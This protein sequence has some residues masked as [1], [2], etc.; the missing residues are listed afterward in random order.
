MLPKRISHKDAVYNLSRA[1]L[2]SASLS[3]GSYHNLRVAAA[4][5]LHQD[6]RLP[7]IEGGARAMALM[8]EEGAYCSYISGAGSTLMAMVPG[9]D[10]S[11]EQRVWPRLCEEGFAAWRLMML[12]ADNTGAICVE[13]IPLH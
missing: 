4:D 8:E 13:S 3:T 6:Y 1:A 12:E 9:A 2:M 10:L 5:R 7:L 11:F